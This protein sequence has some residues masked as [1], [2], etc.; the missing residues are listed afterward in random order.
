MK[1]EKKIENKQGGM[2]GKICVHMISILRLGDVAKYQDC[3]L[4]IKD[5]AKSQVMFG[6]RL[7]LCGIMFA[8][9]PSRQIRFQ[10]AYLR[11]KWF[12]KLNQIV[13]CAVRNNKYIKSLTNLPEV[14][15]QALK[16]RKEKTIFINFKQFFNA[17]K[18]KKTDKVGE[19]II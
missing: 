1:V 13:H 12:L 16:I 15:Q 14:H 5:I 6:L 4:I 19:L 18:K 7:Y 10:Q 2:D 3:L 17:I 9:S 11:K 8:R